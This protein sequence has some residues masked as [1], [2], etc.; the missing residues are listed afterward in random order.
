MD[1][2]TNL[3][4]VALPL[5]RSAMLRGFKHEAEALGLDA[6]ALAAAAGV[7]LAALGSPDVHVPVQGMLAMYEMAAERSGQPDFALRVVGRRRLSNLGL[8]AMLV[9]EERTL[10]QA[11]RTLQRYFW[12]QNEAVELVFEE[13]EDGLLLQAVPVLPPSRQGVDLLLGVVIGAVRGLVG[14]SWQP[15]EVF[16]AHAAPRSLE[17]YQRTFRVIPRFE[18]DLIGILVA[19]ADLE[20]PIPG[21]DP[22]IASQLRRQLEEATRTRRSGFV[23]GVRSLIETRLAKGD[24][25]ID[26]IAGVLGMSRRSLQRLLAQQD[27][28]FSALQEEARRL[29]VGPLLLDSARS[30]ERVAGLLGFASSGSF[31][32]WFRQRF[33]SSPSAFRASGS[34]RNGIV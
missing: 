11:L 12:V 31:S 3:R 30:I 21:A 24:C 5:G 15:L 19:R 13:M 17:S 34:I 33:H 22:D 6:A 20:T 29:L 14:E 7:E 4:G 2:R 8:V 18:Q 16:V 23:A 25:D 27:T 1:A 26:R 28:S 32:Q 10:G 9:R